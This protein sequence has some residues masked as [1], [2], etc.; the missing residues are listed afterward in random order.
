MMITAQDF[1]LCEERNFPYITKTEHPFVVS[2]ILLFASSRFTVNREQFRLE[3]QQ[4][5]YYFQSCYYI[6]ESMLELGIGKPGIHPSTCLPGV[7]G[8]AR[9]KKE[10]TKKLPVTI[11]H[12]VWPWTKPLNLSLQTTC[13]VRREGQTNERRGFIFLGLGSV[14]TP[15]NDMGVGGSAKHNNIAPTV[16]LWCTGGHV[17]L[18]FVWFR[19][20]IPKFCA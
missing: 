18:P 7:H 12:T 2:I 5:R 3:N 6:L 9:A 4:T 15:N 10:T 20:V 11:G 16:D 1:V 14:P 8:Q 19:S 13:H 17:M